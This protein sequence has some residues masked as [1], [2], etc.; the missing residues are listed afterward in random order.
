VGE[1]DWPLH[2]EIA[3]TRSVDSTTTPVG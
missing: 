3:H 1:V 2:L